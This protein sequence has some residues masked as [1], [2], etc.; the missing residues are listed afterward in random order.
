MTPALNLNGLDLSLALPR[1]SGAAAHSTVSVF[2]D[3][4]SLAPV[5]QA[6][7][8]DGHATVF[9]SWAVFQSWVR[10]IADPQKITWV[11]I[12]LVHARTGAPLM[13]LPLAVRRDQGLQTVEFA[14]L[15]VSDY[16]GPVMAASF[17]PDA[18]DMQR[19]WADI[20]DALPA[21]DLLYLAKM[22]KFVN[23]QTNPLLSLAGVHRMNLSAFGTPLSGDWQ[24]WA[25]D[26]IDAK[27]LKDIAARTRKLE[28]R[29]RVTF[30]VTGDSAAAQPVFEAM[31]VQRSERHAAMQRQN[32][33]ARPGYSEFYRAL[34]DASDNGAP[35]LIASLS[36]DDELIATG[37][38]LARNNVFH[39]I[40]PAFKAD[41]WRNYS[42]G[43]QL[44]VR[45]MRWALENG[46][47][48]FDFTIGAEGFKRELGA[49]ER[50]LFEKYAALSPRGLPVIMTSRLKRV[51]RQSPGMAQWALAALGMPTTGGL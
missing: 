42:P 13:L 31:C 22:P 19:H 50:P 32:I 26:T 7:E 3:L 41:R 28:K 46:F 10:H 6:L 24:T 25:T 40:F 8:R 21:G 29:G 2:R 37:Y 20:L 16:N 51:V 35:A 4:A 47:E 27:L 33:L 5:W 9:Q 17:Q 38:G 15:G 36:I 45:T 23:G 39:M 18:R 43:L 12:G 30:E 1:A 34:F 48:Y 11:V 49:T 14:D 44:F